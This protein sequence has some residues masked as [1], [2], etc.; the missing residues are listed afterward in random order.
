MN[1]KITTFIDFITPKSFQLGLRYNYLKYRNKLD[2]E[3]FYVES[4]LN[5]R[6]RFLDIGSNIGTYSYY[7]AKLMKNVEAFEPFTESTIY[8]KNLNNKNIK[9]HNIALSD[10][11]NIQEFFIPIIDNY[12]ISALASLQPINRNN[13]FQKRL[14]QV[15]TL[16]EYNFLDVDLIKIDAEGHEVDIIN[17]AL[18]TL[19]INKPILLVEIEQRHILKPINEIFNTISLLK[20]KGFFLQQGVLKSISDFSY[21]KNQK[22]YLNNVMSSNYINNFIFLPIN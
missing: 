17:G 3:M 9:I 4:L 13:E 8:L 20:Y 16:D 12:P 1:K 10:K 6:R 5:N 2:Q 7:F 15:H 18:K 21:D 19:K 14:V 11:S 22:P